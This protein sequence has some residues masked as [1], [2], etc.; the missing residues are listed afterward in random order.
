MDS[1]LKHSLCKAFCDDISVRDIP[2]G[3]AV[4]TG[5]DGLR[6]DPIGF[7]LIGPDQLG[8]FRVQDDGRTIPFIEASGADL[9]SDSRKTSLMELLSEYGAEYDDDTFEL[10]TDPK[11]VS[12]LPGAT[13]RFVALMLRVQDL[14][15][16]TQEKVASTF[17]EDVVSLLTNAVGDSVKI[18]EGASIA[19]ALGDYEADLVLQ[20]PAHDPVAV[21]LATY[22]SKVQEAIILQLIAQHEAHVPCKVVALLESGSS[23][24]SKMRQ[25]ADNRLDAVPVFRGDE[26]AAI[27]KLQRLATGFSPVIH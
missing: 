3:F 14:L 22:D 15:L 8:R 17:R 24:S 18:L 10:F 20:A 23:I 5:F 25:R 13:M 26:R 16:M 12:Q 21:F 7:Y 27:A 2:A 4:S 19:P 6:G 9:G 11:S 1:D